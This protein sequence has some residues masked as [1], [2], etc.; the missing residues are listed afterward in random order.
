METEYFG[1]SELA[2]KV[3]FA[4]QIIKTMGVILEFPIVIHLDNTGAIYNA[5]NYTTGQRTKHI[6]IRAHLIPE[7]ME[8]GVLKVV[9]IFSEDNRVDIKIKNTIKFLFEKHSSNYMGDVSEYLE[10]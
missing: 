10:D 2:N 7:F 5:D 1:T 8:H 3:I 4:R 6:D 9:F